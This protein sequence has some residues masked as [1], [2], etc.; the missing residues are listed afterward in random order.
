MTIIGLIITIASAVIA[1][2]L[3][4]YQVVWYRHTRP[5]KMKELYEEAKKNAEVIKQ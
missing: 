3:I 4:I 1:I 5:N 2:A